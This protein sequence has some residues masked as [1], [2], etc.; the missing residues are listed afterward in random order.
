MMRRLDNLVCCSCLLKIER[1]ADQFASSNIYYSLMKPDIST[2]ARESRNCPAG[3]PANPSA[4]TGVGDF[5]LG[6]AGL[7]PPVSLRGRRALEPA[8]AAAERVVTV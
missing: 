8:A 7:K 1:A 4:L 2:G 5:Q 6:P 3:L